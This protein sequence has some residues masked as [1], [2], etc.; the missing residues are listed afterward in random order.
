[1]GQPRLALLLGVAL[2]IG[3]LSAAPV[4]L[5]DVPI[6]GFSP[7][8]GLTLTDRFDP[9]TDPTFTYFYADL[10]NSL[11]GTQF[12][13]G[14]P[15]YDLALFDIGAS[16]SLLSSEADA[17]FD[18]DGEGFRG[19]FTLPIGGATGLLEATINDAMAMFA[20]GLGNRMN[21]GPLTFNA[22]QPS[23][24]KGQSSVSILTFPVE[25][26][27]P[28]VVGI[29]FAS[30]FTTFIHNDQPQIFQN[31]GRT[32]RAP[33]IEFLPLGGG[34]QGIA[35]RAPMELESASGQAF[36]GTPLYLP[37]LSGPDDPILPTALQEPGAM[38][39]FTNVVNNGTALSAKKLFFD[40]GA[41]VTVLSTIMALQ[42]GINVGVTPPDFTFD[43]NGSGGTR[44]NIPG[45]FIDELTILA[46]GV[47]PPHL[48]FTNVPVLVF[49]VPNPVDPD[50]PVDGVIGTNILAGR[51]L[52]IDPK[53]TLLGGQPSLYISDPVT[54]SHQ[55]ASAAASGNWET[56][57][58]WSD[59]GTPN[60]LWITTLANV[61]GSPQEVLVAASDAE[62][63]ELN[64]S[65]AGAATMTVRVQ[66]GARLTTFS[67]ANI[68]AGGRVRLDGGTLDA[69]F[70]DIRGGTLTGVG[71]VVTGSG[72][73]PGQVE[74]LSGTVAPG[75]SIGTLNIV[76]R[77]S[78][79][80]SGTLA[81]E[82][83]GQSAGTG[84][85]Q[86]IVEG[87]AALGG[88]LKVTLANPG[89]GTY[90]PNVGDDFTVLLAVGINGE[91]KQLVA[92]P[93][94]NLRA[95]YQ[96]DKV[97]VVVGIQ[98]DYND[99]GVVNAADYT[100]WRNSRNST[101][102]TDADGDGNG[103]IGIGDF[104]VWKSHYGNV[105]PF[106]GSGTSVSSVPEPASLGLL[107]VAALFCGMKRSKR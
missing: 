77:Y 18:V 14:S 7:L 85:D 44:E 101:T 98:G 9:E 91:F 15:Y 103:V 46:G 105:D 11:V 95:E 10:Q 71:T 83:A 25:S 19:G 21:D 84:H 48:T 54:T 61:S 59:E 79:G 70:V 60:R 99:D 38:F 3:R 45:Y 80:D 97:I 65:G 64:V 37:L 23:L 102:N 50:N 94:Y 53:S 30:Q 36:T 13:Q 41:D 31:N 72:P 51:N 66:A 104:T 58:D 2:V 107:L 47:D 73:I 5:A 6:A 39:L 68:K 49:D 22:A 26:D 100:V 93:N 28:S 92:P 1:M 74:N 78:N 16:V 52:V 63:W 81:I 89:G 4:A 67:G 8:V 82:L 33:H 35:R 20:V 96:A 17:A 69:H 88:T 27:L 42:L 24:F 55:W 40:T 29:P 32:V 90:A 87:V 86:L 34:G 75:N 76:G 43:V 56:E 12:G 62:A 106:F 57:T